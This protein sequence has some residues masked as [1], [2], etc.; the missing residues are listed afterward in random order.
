MRADA[1]LSFVVPEL[2]DAALYNSGQSCCAVE[3]SGWRFTWW[4]PPR[5]S[6][7]SGASGCHRDKDKK[8]GA[9]LSPQRIY[10]HASLYDAFV[11][12]F[13][14]FV[15]KEYKLGDPKVEGGEWRGYLV[16]LFYWVLSSLPP[17][18]GAGGPCLRLGE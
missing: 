11:A 5:H 12:Q 14:E 10:V 3:V 8:P 2:V 6:P 4:L 9:H 13:A 17:S 1:D 15:K 18:V 7:N 16:S